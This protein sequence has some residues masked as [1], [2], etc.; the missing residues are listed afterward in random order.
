[1]TRFFILLFGV[2]SLFINDTSIS[3]NDNYKLTWDDFIGN[4]DS[5]SDAVAITAS[6][7]TFSYSISKN[8]DDVESFKALAFAYFYPK[9]SW[10]KLE[11][12]DVHI[13][14]HEQLHFDITELHAR[15]LRQALTKV[16][17]SQNVNE[18]L[19]AAHYQA[20]K[21]LSDM[22]RLYDSECDYSRNSEE[23]SKW[24]TFIKIELDKL[25]DFKTQ[26]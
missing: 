19:D 22:Q 21:A 5:N 1:M 15:K 6:G 24:Q 3:W 8:G 7:I 16:S 12:A 14:A 11:E 17:I 4:P 18:E 23:Q 2:F 26:D 13:L 9:K 10:V 20:N 25:A